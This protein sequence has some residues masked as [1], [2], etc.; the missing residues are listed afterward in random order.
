M[1]LSKVRLDWRHVRNPYDWH[2]ALWQLFPDQ[3]EEKRSFLFRIEQQQTGIGAQLLLQS[4]IVP[5][6]CNAEVQLLAEPKQVDI[7]VLPSGASLRFRLKA[8]VVKTI[9]DEKDAERSI[10][11]PLIKEEQQIEWLQRKLADCASIDSVMLTQ[12]P[13]VFFNRKGSAGKL[14]T[15]TFDGSLQVT[16]LKQ[17][18]KHVQLG[19]GPAKAFGCGLLSLARI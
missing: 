8:N 18:Q 16:D 15:V 6:S 17:F 1:Y 3:P 5:V 19:I 7:S 14:V 4:E 9:R 11:V 13:P 10:R 12:N 2:R